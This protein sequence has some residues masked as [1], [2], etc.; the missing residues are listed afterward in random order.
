MSRRPSYGAAPLVRGH[1]GS[2]RPG[3][4]YPFGYGIIE[5][6]D[7]YY[8]EPRRMINQ[9]Y[10]LDPR[11][12]YASRQ[13]EGGRM[14]GP[15]YP[16][17]QYDPHHRSRRVAHSKDGVPF[18]KAMI[19]LFK[20]I[21]KAEEFYGSFVTD[22]E[23]EI[24]TL[25]RYAP[26]ELLNKLWI[27]RVEGKPDGGSFDEGE[28]IP[29]GEK[30]FVM[31]EEKKSMLI[32]SMEGAANSMIIESRSPKHEVRAEAQ[33]RLREKVQTAH[34]LIMALLDG[35]PRKHSQC[36]SLL[37]ELG[38]LKA[39]VNPEEDA[40]RGLFKSGNDTEDGGDAG[41]DQD[42]G[43]QGGGGGGSGEGW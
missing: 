22:Y 1:R 39:L 32:R 14:P 16:L 35:A 31:F 37:S 21:G 26:S 5:W 43:Q 8:S 41:D 28:E 3:F 10:D 30:S 7:G 25:K 33:K 24:S 13:M 40:N 12:N 15:R 4:N 18:G 27:A 42:D 9:D 6:E 11:Q 19:K 29:E 38:M 23:D 34:K 2:H 17:E 36:K 20:D